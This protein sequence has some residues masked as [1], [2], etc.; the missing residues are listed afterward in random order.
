[1]KK[2]I[3]LILAVILLFS[4]LPINALAVESDF[5]V[6]FSYEVYPE[7]Q[8]YTK[9]EEIKITAFIKNI[10]LDEVTDMRIWMD[11][12]QTDYYLTPGVT[13]RFVTSFNEYADLQFRVIEDRGVLNF[14]SKF[15]NTKLIKR[16]LL[17]L[18]HAYKTLTLAYTTIR[19]GFQ[20]FFVSFGQKKTELGTAKVMYDNTEIEF[21]VKC[22]YSVR[23]SETNEA[24]KLSSNSGIVSADV[25]AVKN[26]YTGITFAMSESKDNYGLFV[27][28]PDFGK[29]CIY[30]VKDGKFNLL[31]TKS[32]DIKADNF[33]QMQVL[34]DSGRVLCYLVDNTFNTDHYP[35]FDFYYESNE[36]G[37]GVFCR[38]EGYKNFNIASAKIP[39]YDKTYTNPVY[40]NT[41]DPYILK[42]NGTYYLYATTDA[43]SGFR[44][45]SST[46]LVNW[47]S[48][49][50]CARKGDI[51]GNDMFWAP[52][53]YKHQGKYYL[54]YSTDEHIALAVADS[55]AG[56][57]V[58][59]KDGYLLEDKCID[60]HF[61]FDDDGTIYL[62]MAYWGKT[63]E[64]IWGCKMAADL[65]GIVRDT[66]T[67]LTSCKYNE[68]GVNEGP[69]M[70]KYQGEYYLTYSVNG[71]TDHNYSVKL[72][73]SDSPLGTYQAK[74]IILEKS[75]P[76]VG[77]GHHSFTTSPDGTE[78]IIAYHCHYST[79]QIH[80]RKL[81][82]DRCKFIPISDGYTISIYGP[83]STSQPYPN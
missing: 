10:S 23:K 15:E 81:C 53:V 19:Y 48:L 77:T 20:N 45:S 65:S 50:F 62:Y 37:Y 70:L 36:N 14:A 6:P 68:G 51:Y 83:T 29:A 56:P 31:G 3:S 43:G 60:G 25:K 32:V 16:F 39:Q 63:G 21:T 8:F 44:V 47:R 49:G 4:V 57:F 66:L 58:K 42:D 78:L 26:S 33:Y 1:M 74:G 61:M 73:V 67:Q 41:P 5:S 7:K 12:P 40:E 24:V 82:I 80:A 54:L 38:Q 52:E 46:D 69:Y 18:A 72:A 64:E 11:Y 55:P 28:N 35:V 13:E 71:Y 22:R 59:T 9:G 34:F 17:R 75:G 76:L 2:Y 30:N 27:M 79:T